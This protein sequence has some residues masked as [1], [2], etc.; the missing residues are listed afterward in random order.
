MKAIS[1]T[2]PNYLFLAIVI[3]VVLHFLFP[4]ATVL[5]G[6]LRFVSAIPMALGAS[7]A[8]LV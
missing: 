6:P 4:G 1:I 5:S 3:M 8:A 2:P 7:V